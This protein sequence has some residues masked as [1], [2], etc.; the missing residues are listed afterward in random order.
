M[1]WMAKSVRRR[2]NNSPLGSW[3]TWI[4][5]WSPFYW[6]DDKRVV[7]KDIFDPLYRAARRVLQLLR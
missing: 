6:D 5:R 4:Y 1:L 7:L 2:G 3:L